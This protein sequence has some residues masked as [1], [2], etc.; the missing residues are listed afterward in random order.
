[1]LS[2]LTAAVRGVIHALSERTLPDS[3]DL[4]YPE[5]SPLAG[6]SAGKL[7]LERKDGGGTQYTIYDPTKDAP[8]KPS[9][10]V[11]SGEFEDIESV[12]AFGSKGSSLA[13]SCVPFEAPVAAMLRD[14]DLPGAGTVTAKIARHPAWVRWT[15]GIG[16]GDVVELGHQAFADLL[17]DNKEDLV[18]PMIAK[19]V[20]SFRAAKTVSYDA[21]LDDVGSIGLRV[22]WKGGA[23]TG[24]VEVPREFAVDVPAYAARGQIVPSA[25]LRM[26]I[27]V[28]VVP[29]KGEGAA[30][31][32]RLIWVNALDYE[33][34]AAAVLSVLIKREC[35]F[36]G[37]EFL[38][39]K[40]TAK[41]FVF[42][43]SAPK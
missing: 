43:D 10:H 31:V 36:R 29:G 27:R 24:T 17:L 26:E 11:R 18:E 5:H 28:R 13:L 12:L 23:K 1:M 41:A 38:R 4:T 14:V 25:K 33:E 15:K 34:E 6:Y 19:L 9:P 30:P 7:V 16:R 32:F 40:Q 8:E 22:E 3:I 35:E 37:I 42:S 20:S 39:G 2:E 21:D